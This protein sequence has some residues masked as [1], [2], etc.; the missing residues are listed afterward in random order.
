VAIFFATHQ[1]FGID[2]DDNAGN[3]QAELV[4]RRAFDR[5][6]G[7]GRKR[8]TGNEQQDECEPD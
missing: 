7:H 5:A 6:V 8:R 4:D 1:R 2:A 3:R